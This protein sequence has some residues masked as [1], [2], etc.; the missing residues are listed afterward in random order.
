MPEKVRS[1]RRE[2]KT[3]CNEPL[4]KLGEMLMNP[5]IKELVDSIKNSADRLANLSENQSDATYLK[6]PLNDILMNANDLLDLVGE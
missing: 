1:W 2:P 4:T 5:E 3:I 6:E